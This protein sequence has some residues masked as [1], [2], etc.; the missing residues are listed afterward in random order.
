MNPAYKHLDSKLRIADL[1]M[2]QWF[3]L[4]LGLSVAL[5]WGFQLSPLGAY[6]T[7]GTSVYLG[8]IPAGAAILA[9]YYEVNLGV[10]V[11]SA[12]TWTHLDGRFVPG[13]GPP[14]PGYAVSPGRGARDSDLLQ[15]TLDPAALWES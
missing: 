11:R 15:S 1:S 6:L 2:G 8:A 3:G 5:L 7:I 4:V 12:L 13:A 10:V 9:G 14:S